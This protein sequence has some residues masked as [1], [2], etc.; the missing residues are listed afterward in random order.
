VLGGTLECIFLL[1][2]GLVLGFWF[3]RIRHGN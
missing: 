2:H 1:P 3:E